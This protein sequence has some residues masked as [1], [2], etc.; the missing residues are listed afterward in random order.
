MR[1]KE[2]AKAYQKKYREENKE[3]IAANQK[4]RCKAYYLAN[5]DRIRERNRANYLKNKVKRAAQNKA[6]Y[7]ANK[8][9]RLRAQK[10]ARMK[11][12]QEDKDERNR[13]NRAWC[14]KRRESDPSWRLVCNLRS[15]VSA[16]LKDAKTIKVEN[17][18]SLFGCSVDEL[19]I[20]LESQ[21]TEGM[22]WDNYGYYGWHVDHIKPCAL[23]N[24]TLDSEQRKCFHYTNLQPLWAKDNLTKSDSYDIS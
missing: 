14:K 12:T 23:F 9:H 17:S 8:E 4:E 15:R 2:K 1:D 20:H 13:K 18:M 10:E 11:M 21:F 6:N 16:A 19:K 3:R 24:L 7:E 22:S 5:I